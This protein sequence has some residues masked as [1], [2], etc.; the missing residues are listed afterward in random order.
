MAAS[1]LKRFYNNG[2]CPSNGNLLESVFLMEVF[3]MIEKINF[4]G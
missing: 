1:L 2:I 3:L 4:L